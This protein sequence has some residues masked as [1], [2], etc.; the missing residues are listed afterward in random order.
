MERTTVSV[1]SM[2][3]TTD[4]IVAIDI[5]PNDVYSIDFANTGLIDLHSE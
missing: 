2:I 1:A 5:E 3:K 4:L